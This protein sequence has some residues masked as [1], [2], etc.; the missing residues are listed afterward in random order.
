MTTLHP[1]SQCLGCADRIL[2]GIDPICDGSGVIAISDIPSSRV[3]VCPAWPVDEDEPP[4]YYEAIEG[5]HYDD[6]PPTMQQRIRDNVMR[7]IDGMPQ[8]GGYE[9]S[10]DFARGFLIAIALSFCIL[11][12]GIGFIAWLA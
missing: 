11:V 3:T 5:L 4:A 9:E 7:E 2:D 12:G 8:D 1:T 10:T 6:I